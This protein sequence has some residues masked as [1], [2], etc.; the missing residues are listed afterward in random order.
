MMK[1]FAMIWL[2]GSGR[3]VPQPPDPPITNHD[4][5]IQRIEEK[6]IGN[7]KLIKMGAG[8][9]FKKAV[10]DWVTPEYRPFVVEYLKNKA[11]DPHY[12]ERSQ[13]VLIALNDE[14]SVINAVNQFND[15]TLISDSILWQNIKIEN[16]KFLIP[17]IYNGSE[18]PRSVD[19]GRMKMPRSHA[20]DF[21]LA[22]IGSS[23][24]CAASARRR[25]A[26]TGTS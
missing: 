14:E 4:E 11:K 23:E 12:L 24:L 18:I 22:V 16:L 9:P 2:L 1:L 19:L 6:Y 26:C 10:V 17:V 20:V 8:G 15:G 25:R 5:L 21:S 7:D 3:P 13:R